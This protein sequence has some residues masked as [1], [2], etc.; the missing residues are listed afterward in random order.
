MELAIEGCL[1]FIDGFSLASSFVA[2]FQ[3]KICP[4]CMLIF[5][6]TVL[7]ADAQCPIYDGG[8]AS[9]V[10]QACNSNTLADWPTLFTVAVEKQVAAVALAVE[11]RVTT[12]PDQIVRVLDASIEPKSAPRRA[13]MSGIP[14]V[15]YMPHGA[16]VVGCGNAIDTPVAAALQLYFKI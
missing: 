5:I 12:L 6:D 2:V 8:M 3:I 1:R 7:R 16:T 4:K 11:Q 14:D 9:E 15:K 13:T 10:V